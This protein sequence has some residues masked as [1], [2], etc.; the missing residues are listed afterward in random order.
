MKVNMYYYINKDG[1]RVD[2]GYYEWA[3]PFRRG[4][5][6]VKRSSGGVCLID[7]HGEIQINLPEY[8]EDPT[9]VHCGRI[10]VSKER[11]PGG[12]G[13]YF[14]FLDTTGKEIVPPQYLFAKAFSEDFAPVQ[15]VSGFRW[16]FIRKDGMQVGAPLF[17]DLDTLNDGLAVATINGQKLFVNSCGETILGPFENAE[18]FFEGIA[19]VVRQGVQL[20]INKKGETIFTNEWD[21]V[22]AICVEGR[23]KFYHNGRSGFLDKF[24]KVVV[25]ALYKEVGFYSE[26]LSIVEGQQAKTG[27]DINGNVLFEVDC[28]WIGEF[29]DGLARFRNNGKYGYLNR[30]GDIIIESKFEWADDFSE[31]LAPVSDTGK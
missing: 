10:L 12:R 4:M 18:S 11:C 15:F 31:G 27:I 13:F 6:C 25:P 2:A 8:Q 5:A 17:Q 29:K 19:C 1:T 24:G 30:Q 9:D 26:G 7:R 3:H 16:A 23:I 20:Y 14:G 28:E 21:S 22:S